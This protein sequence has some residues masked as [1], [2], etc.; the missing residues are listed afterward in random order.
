MFRFRCC[1]VGSKYCR[2]AFA[3][4]LA[5]QEHPNAHRIEHRGFDTKGFVGILG[6]G[7]VH[8]LN[9]VGLVTGHHLVAADSMQ[10]SAHD[11]PLRCGVQ[12]TTFGLFSWQ[13]DHRSTA[14]IYVQDTIHQEYSTPHDL[15]RFT[16][17]FQ[18]TTTQWKVHGG[19]ALTTC[20][21]V[22]ILKVRWRSRTRDLKHPHKLI[23]AVVTLVLR[24]PA[25]V[26]QS[27]GRIEAQLGPHAIGDQRVDGSTLIDFVEVYNSFTIKQF[28]TSCA[29]ENWRTLHIVHQAFWEV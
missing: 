11:R 29:V 4:N 27:G 5:T 26:M 6:G 23:H 7:R 14:Q 12:K 13:I 8:H 25:N 17:T 22:S 19:L 15:S 18:R 20:P 2:I 28:G 16:D 9:V 3:S 21:L 10:N 1:C 24:A